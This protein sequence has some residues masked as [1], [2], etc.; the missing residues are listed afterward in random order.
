MYLHN[1]LCPIYIIKPINNCTPVLGVSGGEE[2]MVNPSHHI[3]TVL[4]TLTYLCQ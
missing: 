3:V 4:N 2:R 1:E